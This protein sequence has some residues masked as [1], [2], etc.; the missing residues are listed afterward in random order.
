MG[1]L[2][3]KGKIKLDQFWPSGKSDADTTKLI[4]SLDPDAFSFKPDHDSEFHTTAIFQNARVK[5]RGA[6]VNVI[7]YRNTTHPRINIRL[8]GIDAPELHYKLYGGIPKKKLSPAEYQR[9]KEVN[10]K[11]EFRQYFAETATVNLWQLLKRHSGNQPE[12]ECVFISH[13]VNRPSDVCDVYG[14]FVGD[15]Y[16]NEESIN[17][18][19][20]LLSEGWV[21]PAFY[22]SMLDVEIDRLLNCYQ[23]G[24]S[25]AD[26]LYQ[27]YTPKIDRFDAQ[28]QFRDPKDD[29]VYAP[30]ADRG[31]VILPKFFRR[32]SV[33]NLYQKAGID[34]GTFKEYL[35]EKS[36]DRVVLKEKLAQFRKKENV[37]IPLSKLLIDD[38]VQK[39][40]EEIIFI[41]GHSLLI[42]EKGEEIGSF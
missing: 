5:G 2:K 31:A 18:N 4:M 6:P 38:T 10:A 42:D 16:L 19:H 29:P 23:K 15:L 28:L 26:R 35:E 8:E 25:F 12:V 17:I 33:Y 9:L 20:W 27:A 36:E 14:R 1:T 30:V 37:S 7:K 3:I 22:D 11:Y 32:W 40:P 21:F 41:E 39:E 24:K 13:N 34:L